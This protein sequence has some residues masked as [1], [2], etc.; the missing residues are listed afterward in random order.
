MNAS[1][2]S[3]LVATTDEV[4]ELRARVADLEEAGRSLRAQIVTLREAVYDLAEGKQP[5]LAGV[6]S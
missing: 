5:T 1:L 3:Q 2:I 6:G 4:R